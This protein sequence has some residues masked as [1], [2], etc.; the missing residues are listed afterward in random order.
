MSIIEYIDLK[1]QK[2]TLEKSYSMGSLSTKT[3]NSKIQSLN[4]QIREHVTERMKQELD[5]FNANKLNVRENHF[6]IKLTCRCGWS[7]VVSYV[8]MDAILLGKD[9]KGFIYFQCPN[10]W[11]KL[12]F[13][14]KTG[15]TKTRKGI[16]GS[17]FGK[18]S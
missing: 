2:K 15:K 4:Q 7:D 1:V 18:Y 6:T 17:L 14:S 13:D 3:Y 16:L 10:C 5:G 8:N 11:S 12:Q 9:K